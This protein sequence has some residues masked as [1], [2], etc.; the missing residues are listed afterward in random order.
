MTMK[1][2][3]TGV[4]LTAAL[5]LGLASAA[6][7]QASAN[8]VAVRAP[9]GSDWT[10]VFSENQYIFGFGTANPTIRGTGATGYAI[11]DGAFFFRT[12]LNCAI[13]PTAGVWGTVC[14][15][16]STQ[17]VGA[18]SPT[19]ITNIRVFAPSLTPA[20]TSAAIQTAEQTFT[21]TGLATTDKVFVNGP[22]PTSL[23][24]PV[25]FRVSATDTLAIGFSTLTA[26][27]CTPAAGT[28]NIVAVRS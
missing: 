10:M 4:A 11:P 12:D 13:T 27:G 7:A 22:V 23:C 20:I 9:N 17:T 14:R 15:T 8:V 3:L 6:S 24:P 26:A 28:Y 25:T 16:L 5:L 21:V 2:I 1:R 18:A 19:A